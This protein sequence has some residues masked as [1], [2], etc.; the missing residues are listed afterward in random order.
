M[1]T[2]LNSK[3]ILSKFVMRSFGISGIP[4]QKYRMRMINR[5]T[6]SERSFGKNY[7]IL[8]HTILDPTIL[9]HTILDPTIPYH[10]MTTSNVQIML[11]LFAFIIE[12]M[13]YLIIFR[14]LFVTST[15]IIIVSIFITIE[16]KR[17]I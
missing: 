15:K 6:C 10:I 13:F 9:D 3:H 11:C 7:I 14:S 2:T 5:L 8:D 12:N 1:R 17:N 4:C 16:S